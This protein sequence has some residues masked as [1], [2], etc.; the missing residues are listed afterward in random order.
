MKP[1]AKRVSIQKPVQ[2]HAVLPA[3]VL[4]D[5]FIR[6]SDSKIRKVYK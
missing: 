6:L 3:N 2:N 5:G 4:E 1:V